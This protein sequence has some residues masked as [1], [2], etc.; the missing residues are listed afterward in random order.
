MELYESTK[1]LLQN[2]N[3]TFKDKLDLFEQFF[4]E[5]KQKE[6]EEVIIEDEPEPIEN[7]PEPETKPEQPIEPPCITKYE[8]DMSIVEALKLMYKEC[9]KSKPH[10]HEPSKTNR[11]YDEMHEQLK[12]IYHSSKL[13]DDGK[14]FPEEL[15]VQNYEELSVLR[16]FRTSLLRQSRHFA[17]LTIASQTKHNN[18]IIDETTN[19][20]QQIKPKKKRFWK[21]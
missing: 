18:L 8:P 6:Q 21:K 10:K 19:V 7:I 5:M 4:A 17:S 2:D 12:R 15:F 9:N 14:V 20:N 16:E 11:I 3:L 1:N 13:W